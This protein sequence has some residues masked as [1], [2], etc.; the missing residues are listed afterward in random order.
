MQDEELSGWLIV[1][2]NY[3]RSNGYL[4]SSIALIVADQGA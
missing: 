4:K 3:I 2:E 1:V